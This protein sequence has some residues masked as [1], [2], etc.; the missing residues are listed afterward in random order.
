MNRRNLNSDDNSEAAAILASCDVW[1]MTLPWL[2]AYWDMDILARY[3]RCGFTF[4]SAT[5]QDW[6]ATFEGTA[7]CIERFKELAKPH[8]HWLTFGSSLA[9]IEQGRREGK[10]V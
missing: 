4:I 6:P 9:E 3:R 10:L 1:E 5:L 2:P 8:S 7:S